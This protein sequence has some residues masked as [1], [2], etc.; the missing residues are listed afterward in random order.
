LVRVAVVLV[1]LGFV[2]ERGADWAYSANRLAVIQIMG[3]LRKGMAKADVERILSQHESRF[4]VRHPSPEGLVWWTKAGLVT[5][6]S[7][8]VTFSGDGRL[9][10]A[11]VSTED[12]PYHPNGVPPDI[13]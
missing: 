13:R 10:T 1:A 11:R 2:A 12:G 6:W 8:G 7:I 4:F 9:N 3:Q 5:A